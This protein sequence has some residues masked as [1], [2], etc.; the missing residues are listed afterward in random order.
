[1]LRQTRRLPTAAPAHCARAFSSKRSSLAPPTSRVRGDGIDISKV[2]PLLHEA[3]TIASADA[4]CKLTQFAHGQSNPTYLLT[5]GEQ[6]LVLRKQPP[7]KLLRGAHAIDREYAAMT[8]L[9]EK[10]KVPVPKMRLFVEDAEVLGTPFFVCDYVE[11]RFFDDPLCTGAGSPQEVGALYGGFLSAIAKL[12]TADYHAAGLGDFGKEGGYVARQTKVWTAQYRAA[13]TEPNVAFEHL[14]AWLPEAMPE[15]DDLTTLVHG[16]LRIDNCIFAPS[17]PDVIAMLDWELSTLGHPA[18]D[19]ALATMPY[20]TPEQ[21][22][23]AFRGFGKHPQALGVPSEQDF[24]DRYV[25]ATG[26]SSVRAPDPKLP[27]GIQS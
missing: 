18:A 13:E 5:L 10:T 4:E 24:V 1:M 21:M 11:G 27:C 20:D 15:D 23:K 12:H 25:D 6:K 8:A 3:G 2:L 16:D 14:V 17:S 22:P 19:L 7:G 9:G 26:L